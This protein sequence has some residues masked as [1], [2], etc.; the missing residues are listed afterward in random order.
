MS[1]LSTAD[2]A[3]ALG[4]S[5]RQAQRLVAAGKVD[6]AHRAGRAYVVEETASVNVL[7]RGRPWSERT[8]WAALGML[9]GDSLVDV[10][11]VQRRRLR[12]R[13]AQLDAGALASKVRAHA[14]W[15]RYRTTTSALAIARE[16]LV[17]SGASAASSLGVATVGDDLASVCGY[18]TAEVARDLV[19]AFAM[20]PDR[21]GNLLLAVPGEHLTVD[22]ALMPAGVVAVD[23]MDSASERDRVV[24]REWIDAALGAMRHD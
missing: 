9:S 11:A 20:A 23:L 4:V 10:D 12:A 13:M 3:A 15:Q 7:G 21:R 1:Y 22:G 8:A 14:A 24:G 19:T 18:C 16:R 6:G 2:L 17:L 5:R